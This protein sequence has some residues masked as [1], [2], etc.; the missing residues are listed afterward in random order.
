MKI[1]FLGN[2]TPHSIKAEKY[3]KEL[4]CDIVA[5]QNKHK[6]FEKYA[7]EYDIGFSF[8]YPFLVPSIE[9]KKT[10][11]VNF[12]PAPLPEYGG[13]NV[14]YH[15]IMNNE[16]R[17]GG[18]IH[19]MD[20][21]FDTGNIVEV[22]YFEI[23]ESDTAY[24]IYTR[25]CDVLLKLF[26]K[27]VPLFLS[28]QEISGTAQSNHKY[29]KKSNIDDFIQISDELKKEIKAKTYPPFYPKI[30]IGEKVYKLVTENE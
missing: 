28:G 14:A 30:R 5:I 4:D 13:R 20:K 15:A 2:G 22:Y 23:N 24:D 6:R 9:I 12:H 8:L 27:Y 17:F 18:T 3:I 21:T 25:S 7:K 16:R 26:K 1:I 19:Y 11:W 29:Y 10:L